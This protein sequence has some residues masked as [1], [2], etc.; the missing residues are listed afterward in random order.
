MV[1]CYKHK[2]LV[3]QKCRQSISILMTL[4]LFIK[5]NRV[6]IFYM[7]AMCFAM[8]MIETLQNANKKIR[9]AT[10]K[11]GELKA[12]VLEAKYKRALFNSTRSYESV[13]AAVN[14]SRI[15]DHILEK[16]KSRCRYKDY[17]LKLCVKRKLQELISRGIIKSDEDIIIEICIDEQLTATNGYYSLED[18]IWEEL[19]HGIA[20]WDYGMVHQNVFSQDVSVHIHYCDSSKY[21]LIQAAD[22]LANRIWTSYRVGNPDLRKINNHMFLTFP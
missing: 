14:L 1:L 15:Y 19:K 21:Y 22:I 8:S 18:S 13:S 2:F 17:I 9:Q 10:G 11:T 5:M 7:R 16:K 12:S 6:G 4:E 3:R 20:N